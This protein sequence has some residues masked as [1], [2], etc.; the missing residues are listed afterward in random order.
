MLAVA[1]IVT[2]VIAFV[3]YV[4]LATAR[5]LERAK[6]TGIRKTAGANKRML[7]TQFLLESGLVN[8]VSFIGAAVVTWFL[9]PYFQS[10]TDTHMEFFLHFQWSELV[11]L[12]GIF[13]AISLLSGYYPALVLASFDPITA[14]KGKITRI[15]RGK[16][17]RKT[18]VVFQFSISVILIAVS[19]IVSQQ[20][21]FMQS[22]DTG[23]STEQVLVLKIPARTDGYNEKLEE[24]RNQMAKLS[25]VASVTISSSVA[26]YEVAMN[27]ANRRA[28][29][30]AD[31]TN[32]FEMLRTDPEF[33]ETFMLELLH[34]R[35]FSRDNQ[36]DAQ[37]IIVN[38]E[39]VKLLGYSNPEQALN[40][41]VYLETSDKK[42]TIIGVAKNYHQ[43]SLK[44]DY[45]PIMFFISP[46]FGWIP[47]SYVSLKVTSVDWRATIAA[48]HEQWNTI[49]PESSFDYFFLDDHIHQQYKNDI[50][51]GKLINLFCVLIIVIACLGLL[52]LAS[53]DT[54]LRRR[55]VGIRKALGASVPQLLLLLSKEVVMLLTIAFAIA[56][57]LAY[58]IGASWLTNYSFRLE[59]GM[60][61][62]VFPILILLPIALMTVTSQA[63]RAALTNPI[64]SLRHE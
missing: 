17:I 57:P 56:L 59:I 33:I 44:D 10:V 34:G 60:W 7:I 16:L 36:A 20:V 21:K 45:K 43:T 5:A 23:I 31:Q 49:F 58:G 63:L 14:L 6:E 3:N 64:E 47:Y 39:A 25:A 50:A 26:G 48:V 41:E 29:A 40:K 28:E 15:G 11:A 9:H 22:K 12:T 8:A 52:G 30:N 51:F 46:E 37:A 24:L 13:V 42:F 27:L 32:L 53:Y 38:E 19:I 1:A 4:N 18:L 2:L 55:E 35:N 62:L 61:M 54:I